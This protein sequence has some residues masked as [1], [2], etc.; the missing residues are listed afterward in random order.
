MKKYSLLFFFILL[1]SWSFAQKTLID[2]SI[3]SKFYGIDKQIDKG[4]EPTS[5]FIQSIVFYSFKLKDRRD[6]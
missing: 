1:F 2:E 6:Y 4:F 3:P 5:N